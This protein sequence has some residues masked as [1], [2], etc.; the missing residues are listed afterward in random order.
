VYLHPG[1]DFL[2]ETITF[3]VAPAVTTDTFTVP[4]NN[5]V[6]LAMLV[7]LMLSFGCALSRRR[8]WER[9]AG[10]SVTTSSDD[11]I[12]TGNSMK[13]MTT[14]AMLVLAS[15]ASSGTAGQLGYNLRTVPATPQTGVPFVAAFDSNECEIWVLPPRVSLLSSLCRAQPWDWKSTSCP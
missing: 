11:D 14:F 15:V 6:A 12:G 7:G 9:V 1:N 10:Y 3:Q 8:A 4:A 13:A 2:V 5:K